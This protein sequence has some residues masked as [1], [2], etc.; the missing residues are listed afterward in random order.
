MKILLLVTIMLASVGCQSTGERMK[1]CAANCNTICKDNPN[2]T[3]FAHKSVGG[4][5]LLFVGG[6]E[7]KCGC[8]RK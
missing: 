2:I 6:M 4:L 1:E 7:M 8:N 5:T 3:E